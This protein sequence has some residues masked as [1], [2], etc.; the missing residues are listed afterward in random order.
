MT[1]TAMPGIRRNWRTFFFR[2]GG[3]IR[4]LQVTG[5][6][7]CAL[8]IWCRRRARAHRSELRRGDERRARVRARRGTVVRAP[9]SE[10]RRVGKEGRYRGP[11]THEKKKR[12]THIAELVAGPAHCTP[13]PLTTTDHLH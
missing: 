10:E 5:V 2:A 12:N 9:R 6:Q 3:G 8:P 1:T 11:A 7:T 13:R 4:V